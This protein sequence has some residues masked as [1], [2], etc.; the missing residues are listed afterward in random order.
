MESITESRVEFLEPKLFLIKITNAWSTQPC[1]SH[2]FKGYVDLEGGAVASKSPWVTVL[3]DIRY[4]F[5]SCIC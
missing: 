2:L 1:L 5:S 3:S 4:V